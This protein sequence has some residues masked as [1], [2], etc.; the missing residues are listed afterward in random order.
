[1]CK[2]ITPRRVSGPGSSQ[3]PHRKMEAG[4]WPSYAY[5]HDILGRGEKSGGTGL[6]RLVT[7]LQVGGFGADP[8]TQPIAQKALS[9]GASERHRCSRASRNNRSRDRIEAG[10]GS[11]K[12]ASI[13]SKCYP[14]TI[15]AP[16]LWR[17][18]NWHAECGGENALDCGRTPPQ[19]AQ[20]RCDGGLS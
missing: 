10:L 1:M 13:E 7:D 11:H 17:E 14:R 2:L 8:K 3:K 12:H 9:C 4:P 6:L 5:L 15:S 16:Q 20:R 18:Q 19:Y